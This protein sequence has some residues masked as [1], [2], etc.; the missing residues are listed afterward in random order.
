MPLHIVRISRLTARNCGFAVFRQNHNA[1]LPPLLFQSFAPQ[2][3]CES[4]LNEFGIP[5]SAVD[6]RNERHPFTVAPQR[7]HLGAERG[8]FRPPRPP[9]KKHRGF[10][11]RSAA[12]SAVAVMA[13]ADDVLPSR[14]A[15]AGAWNHMV[16]VKL[17][18][19]E[20]AAAVLAGI[21][22]ARE[23]I[24]AGKPHVAL[25][26]S[27]VRRQQQHPRNTDQSAHSAYAFVMNFDRK[28]PPGIKIEG[29]ILLVNS[30]RNPLIKQGKC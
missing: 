1:A 16:E 23:D 17:G 26:H 10:F 20:P 9:N 15:A 24:E 4:V 30:S 3:G 7:K 6:L 8:P 28:V 21:V 22:V 12:L 29:A 11:R 5:V 25:W 19:R 13:G 2:R 27:F 14:S 18:A